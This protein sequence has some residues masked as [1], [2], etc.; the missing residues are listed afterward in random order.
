MAMA[1]TPPSRSYRLCSVTVTPLVW[2]AQQATGVLAG[3]G[4]R[5]QRRPPTIQG[6][7]QNTIMKKVT[8][9]AAIIAVPTAVTGFYGMNVPYPGFGQPSGAAA[10][11]VLI[12]ILSGALY[13]LFKRLDWL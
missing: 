8:S 12:V 3:H 2:N 13:L 4:W 10:S 6:N 5:S 1:V 11:T 7:R 9:W